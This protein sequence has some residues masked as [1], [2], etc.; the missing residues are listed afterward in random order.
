MPGWPGWAPADEL[1]SSSPELGVSKPMIRLGSD[2]IR[3]DDRARTAY[4]RQVQHYLDLIGT[5]VGQQRAV[6]ILSAMTGT[7][8]VARAVNNEDFSAGLLS[9]VADGL[10]VQ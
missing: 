6:L 1:A 8:M 10:L 2:V 7:L 5:G 4:T 3:C 9:I